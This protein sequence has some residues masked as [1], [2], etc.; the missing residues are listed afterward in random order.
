VIPSWLGWGPAGWLV[1]DALAVYR[2][3]RLVARDS[4][5]V[6]FRRWLE[7]RYEGPLVT[8]STCL[9]CLSVSFAAGTVLFTWWIPMVWSYVAAGLAFSAVA[10]LLSELA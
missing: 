5:T 4:I 10:G 1:V 8:L 2:L 9:W 3:S 6:K 7:A